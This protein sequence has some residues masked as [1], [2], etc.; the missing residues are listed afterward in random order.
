MEAV[1]KYCVA[2]ALNGT[3]SECHAKMIG[4]VVGAIAFTAFIVAMFTLCQFSLAMILVIATVLV[5]IKCLPP[6]SDLR[7]WNDPPTSCPLPGSRR[8]KEGEVVP[9][10]KRLDGRVAPVETSEPTSEPKGVEGVYALKGTDEFEAKLG[11]CGAKSLIRITSDEESVFHALGVEDFLRR[12]AGSQ[13]E[14]G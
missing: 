14:R 13:E 6:L 1:T 3:L 10:C 5:F 7:F 8:K 9:V 2:R 4:D 11:E 12:K